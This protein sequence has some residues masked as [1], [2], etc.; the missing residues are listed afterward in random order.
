M[1]VSD[2]AGT[3]TTQFKLHLPEPDKSE[4]VSGFCYEKVDKKTGET[5]LKSAEGRLGF[6]L[7]KARGYSLMKE[8]TARSYLQTLVKHVDVDRNLNLAKHDFMVFKQ[9]SVIDASA[10]LSSIKTHKQSDANVLALTQAVSR[11]D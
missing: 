8:S 2:T 5:K 7:M 9:R 10:F 4:K 1:R 11:T 6:L 3:N